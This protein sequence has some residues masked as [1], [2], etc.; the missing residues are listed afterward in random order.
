MDEQTW[1]QGIQFEMDF[2]KKWLVTKG[3]DWQEDY[4]FR[5]DP[6]SEFQEGFAWA[7]PHDVTNP[8]ILDVG[9]GPMT[10][11]GKKFR[12]RFLDITPVDALG[13]LYSELPLQDC[14]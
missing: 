11:L 3:G 13:D 9:A 10:F 12:G 6:D 4:E 8:K 2:W 14:R 7:L 1:S 5:T